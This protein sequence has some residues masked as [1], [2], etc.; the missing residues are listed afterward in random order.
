MVRFEKEN[1]D[2]LEFINK[3]LQKKDIKTLYYATLDAVSK[4]AC[5]VLERGGIKNLRQL[6]A[7]TENDIRSL[8][9]CGVIT[10]RE[11]VDMQARLT[12][13]IMDQP[14]CSSK[15]Y[16]ER[17][18]SGIFRR[19]DLE[20]H[21]LHSHFAPIDPDNPYPSLIGWL[22]TQCSSEEAV[23]V[24]LMRKGMTGMPP[25]SLCE[26]AAKK[27][28]YRQR[29]RQL[30]KSVERI[31]CKYSSSFIPLIHRAAQTTREQGG[32]IDL[33][34]LAEGVLARGDG[35]NNLKYAIPFICLLAKMHPWHIAGL[36]LVRKDNAD[37]DNVKKMKGTVQYIGGSR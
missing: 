6:I 28:F 31:C 18:Y 17:I 30:D 23:A 35:G 34:T 20:E 19:N 14:D 27:E 22:G 3:K 26:V 21:P 9:M 16:L 2:A 13:L 11:I 4:R 12:S 15:E 5:S 32:R 10:T 24:F 8:D 36:K 1:I 37:V 29:G 7:M 25:M 33:P